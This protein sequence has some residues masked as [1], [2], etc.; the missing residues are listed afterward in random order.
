[1]NL[2][3]YDVCSKLAWRLALWPHPQ[4]FGRGLSVW[5]SPCGWSSLGPSS[6]SAKTCRLIGDSQLSISVNGF[7]S[8]C[9]SPVTCSEY[10]LPMAAGKGSSPPKTW[11]WIS[12]RKWMAEYF[13]FWHCSHCLVLYA[14]L[15]YCWIYPNVIVLWGSWTA[16]HCYRKWI[17]LFLVLSQSVSYNLYIYTCYITV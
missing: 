3:L 9:V 2:K 5:T 11:N 14:R 7:L 16:I 10:T 6:H 15:K 12:G 8:L 1:M 13:I 4:S 17:P